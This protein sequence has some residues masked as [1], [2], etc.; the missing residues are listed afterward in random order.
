MN[1]YLL[2]RD[3]KQTGPYTAAELAEKGLKA[4]DLV[5]LEG[6][7]AAWRYPSELAELKPFAPVVEEQPYDRFYKKPAQESHPALDQ[8]KKAALQGSAKETEAITHQTAVAASI[9]VQEIT[10]VENEAVSQEEKEPE[11]PVQPVHPKKIYV[12]LPASNGS[13]VKKENRKT[14]SSFSQNISTIADERPVVKKQEAV[15]A[16]SINDSYPDNTSNKDLYAQLQENERSRPKQKTSIRP[17][18]LGLVAAC[19]LLFGVIIGLYISNMKQQ[20]QT[21]ALEDLVK[22][23]QLR[24]QE[25]NTA[26]PVTP[27][28]QPA[29][30][31][32]QA[33]IDSSNALN[34]QQEEPQKKLPISTVAKKGNAQPDNKQPALNTT[35]QPEIDNS[36]IVGNTAS[37]QEETKDKTTYQQAAIDAARKNIHQMLLVENSKYK[38]GV[39]G[40]ISNLHMTISNNSRFPLDQVQIE[41]KYFG[42]EQKLV[43]TQTLLFNDL[44]PGEQKTLEAPRTSRG[45]TIDYAIT[46]INSKVL[47]LAQHQF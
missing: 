2:L 32:Q 27:K 17:L 19:L 26:V 16:V 18:T 44:A 40:G 21:R 25:R 14:A 36:D 28:D 12:N 47:G 4:Y 33:A 23:I 43:K 42:P 46:R 13:S 3:N 35:P 11:I 45:T 10:P 39:L 1:K 30:D 29:Q 37:Q 38:T 5:W 6:K 34:N 8:A 20:T 22:S 31:L 24:D 15:A 9:S 7:S 41:I